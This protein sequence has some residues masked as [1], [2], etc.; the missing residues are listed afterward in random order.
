MEH[1]LV[2][3]TTSIGK[4]VNLFQ[5]T[6]FY[7]KALD[8]YRRSS[9]NELLVIGGATFITFYNLVSY[10]KERRQKLNLPPRV[11]YAFPLL[12]HLPY[13]LYDSNRFLDWCSEK[14]GDLYDLNMAG[15]VITVATGRLAEEAMKATSD[16]LSLEE[17]ILKGKKKKGKKISY[18]YL[19]MNIH[20]NTIWHCIY[21]SLIYALCN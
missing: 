11:G 17:G 2:S 13:I 4:A 7:S 3:A 15:S 6:E 14:Y 20:I 9:R 19:P 1:Y 10:I 5:N 21:R 18:K 8:F 16:E 12:G